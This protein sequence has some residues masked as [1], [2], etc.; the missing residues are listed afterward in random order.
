[1]DKI[2]THLTYTDRSVP[3]RTFAMFLLALLGAHRGINTPNIF[4]PS[5]T[6]HTKN[7]NQQKKE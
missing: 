5:Q 3:K 4:F 2:N 6:I 7:T 1:M